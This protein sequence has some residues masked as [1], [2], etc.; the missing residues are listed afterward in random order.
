MQGVNLRE[1][2]GSAMITEETLGNH[3]GRRL[4]ESHIPF[5]AAF[6]L[7][8]AAFTL[9]F[10]LGGPAAK[11]AVADYPEG[12]GFHL[13]PR[14][15]ARNTDIRVLVTA[16]EFKNGRYSFSWRLNGHPVEGYAKSTFPGMG[17]KEGDRVSLVVTDANGRAAARDRVT[18]G[19]G[20]SGVPGR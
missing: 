2:E 6:V 3:S 5:I 13:Q 20:P 15:P 4:W 18:V 16:E 1:M 17:L 9:V 12:R 10:F 8:L 19:H 7:V 11:W 14:H